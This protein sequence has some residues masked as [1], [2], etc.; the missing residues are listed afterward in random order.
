MDTVLFVQVL[1]DTSSLDLD[2]LAPYNNEI[3]ETIK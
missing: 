2:F 1:V 3:H